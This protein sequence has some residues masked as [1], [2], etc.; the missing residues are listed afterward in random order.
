MSSD[1][2]YN[3]IP[4]SEKKAENLEDEMD[5]RKDTRTE[6]YKNKCYWFIFVLRFLHERPSRNSFNPRVKYFIGPCLL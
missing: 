6:E 5:C 2:A 3:K 4:D 1:Q